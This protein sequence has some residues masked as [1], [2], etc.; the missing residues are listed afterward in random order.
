MRL[1]WHVLHPSTPY[2]HGW[3]VEA[4]CQHLEAVTDGR[5]N[6][7]LLNVPPGSSKSVIV[8]VMWQAWEWGPKNMPHL[9]YISTSYREDYVKRDTRRT[10]DL[11]KS[12]WYQKLWGKR[13]ALTREAELSFANDKGGWREGVPFGSLTGGRADRLLID[14]PHSVDTAESELERERTIR[15]FRESVPLRVND[16]I[17]SAIVVIMQRLHEQDVSGQI[18]KLKLPYERVVIPMEFESDRPSSTTIGWHDPRTYDGELMCPERFPREVVERDKV[19]MG[20]YGVACQFQQRPSPR[21]GGMFR[22]DWFQ[23]YDAAPARETLCIYGASDY[24]VTEGGG[25]FTVHGVFG[26][27]PKDRIFVLDWWRAQASPEV[28]IEELLRLAGQWQPSCWA[29]EG[30]QIEKSVGPFIKKRQLE[31][32]NYFYRRQFV[33]A[34]D[35]PTRAQAIRARIAMGMVYLPQGKPWA[36]DLVDECVNFPRRGIDDQVDVLSLL[37]RML[38][39]LQKGKELAE[40]ESRW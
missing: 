16:P 14:D 11:I 8:S 40:P 32:N 17:R 21:G 10:R 28:W 33:S 37:G 39:S 19:A 9:Q 38:G 3:N 20:E 30:G 13:F 26:V 6:R 24:A 12:E 4:I 36:V 29:E 18:E 1:A 31:T 15:T 7:L 35:K 5:I 34:R 27:D 25:D 22:A 23:W 2:V